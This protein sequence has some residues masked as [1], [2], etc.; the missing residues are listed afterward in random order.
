MKKKTSPYEQFMAMT[1]AERDAE[2]GKYDREFVPTKPLTAADRL[3]LRR[4]RRKVG[5]PKVGKGAASVL[6]SMERGLL[7]TVDR[8]A[9]RHKITRSELIA[10]SLRSMLKAG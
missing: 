1:D 5:R 4:A 6:I 10:R 2:V 3:A 9:K 8:Y 7:T